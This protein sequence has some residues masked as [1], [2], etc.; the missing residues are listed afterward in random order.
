MEF[1]IS[2]DSWV[3]SLPMGVWLTSS[4]ISPGI[5]PA[6]AAGLPGSI[7]PSFTL[8][9]MPF[10]II[11]IRNRTKARIKFMAGPAKIDS[12]RLPTLLPPNWRFQ[13]AIWVS[14]PLATITASSATANRTGS[15]STIRR[16]NSSRSRSMLSISPWM[17]FARWSS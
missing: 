15:P 1:L 3:W 7:L 10:I 17:T 12:A 8:V 2:W 6:A 5:R 4:T 9:G 16:T 13:G 11:T 14:L